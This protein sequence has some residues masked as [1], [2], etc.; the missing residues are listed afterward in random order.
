MWNKAGLK[1]ST[2]EGLPGR[3]SVFAPDRKTLFSRAPPSH[4]D[5][6]RSYTRVPAEDIALH[7]LFSG[8][9]TI[10][11]WCIITKRGLYKGDLGYVVA[12]DHK[13]GVLD[14]LVASRYLSPL[15][16]LPDDEMIGEDPH[17]RRLFSQENYKGIGSTR[18]HGHPTFVFQNRR[19][20]AGLLLLQLPATQVRE[21]PTPSPHQISLHVHSGI[22]PAFMDDTRRRYHQTFWKPLDRVVVNDASYFQLH[23]QLVSVD[24]ENKS[25]VVESIVE[26]ENLAVSLAALY[27]VYQPGDLVRVIADPCS[28]R[29]NVHHE[30]IGKFG[31]VTEVDYGT[32]EVTFLDQDHSLVSAFSS[33]NETYP[34]NG[35]L[36][37]RSPTS[38][39]IVFT[40]SPLARALEGHRGHWP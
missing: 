40:R 5:C 26:R 8:P 33:F 3:V 36:D 27:R 10:P 24:L 13:S 23:S 11:A 19:Y 31:L 30:N 18:M 7:A 4:I 39:R 21:L 14:I 38:S 15:P 12:F 35:S 25:A 17:A 1:S 34:S 2:I 29:R 20:I 37:S 22:A 6:I 9:R 16:R 32:E 28:D